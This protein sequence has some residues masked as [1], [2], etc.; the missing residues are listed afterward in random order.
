MPKKLTKNE[1][2]LRAITLH[3]DKYDYSKVD[4]VNLK[5]EVVITCNL[6]GDFTQIAKCHL[7]GSK[8]PKC[9]S[10]KDKSPQDWF[11]TEAKKVHGDRYD[12]STVSVKDKTTPIEIKC[13]VH[14]SFYQ[15]PVNH[16]A[17]NN[18]ME[19][20]REESRLT[21][22]QFISKSKE[23]HGN[24]Y[25][26]DNTSYTLAD[27]KVIITCPVHGDFL[28][29]PY[30]HMDGQGCNKCKVDSTRLTTE[31]FI[32]KAIN[33]HKNKYSY[34]KVEYKSNKEPVTIYCPVHGY[35]NQIADYHMQ[36]RGCPECGLTSYISK[37]EN[38]IVSHIKSLGLEV[39]QS[40][41]SLI[42]PY[43]LDIII[44]EKKIAIEYNGIRWHSEKFGKDKYYHKNKTNL[45][46]DKGYRL[47]HIW[48]DDFINDAK[49]EL[50]FIS[51]CLGTSSQKKVYARQ[52]TIKTI[53]NKEGRTF[54]DKHHIQ[55]SGTGTF[56]Y[57][58]FL[59]DE[60]IAVTSFL[61]KK[62]HAELTRHTSDRQIVGGL[63]K[64]TKLVS[65]ELKQDIL[66]FCDL[67]RFDGKSYLTCGYE[68]DKELLPDYKY[69]VGNERQHKFVWRKKNIEKKLPDIYNPD[70]T[71][72]EMMELADIPRIWDCGKL[73]LIYKF[74]QV[75][76]QE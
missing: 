67:S 3:G 44:P 47:I 33:I 51:Y 53:S 61:V 57:G 46:K 1:F 34:D 19:C 2:I 12:Y 31:T 66:S 32:I 56:Y 68:I 23:K 11:I 24:Y 58:M 69:V 55:G 42:S 54:L 65:K 30:A 71:E 10:Y 39:Q 52:T 21:T 63:G 29:K 7:K 37:A 38:T 43:E 14:G 48:E 60:L 18:C 76:V 16:L 26:Y 50:D 74:K 72:K 49:K 6:H 15:Q 25:S 62:D 70:L 59:E 28:Q 8:C 27:E 4:F 9:Y 20:S 22:E 13:K 73:R 75:G 17:G 41:R 35:Y 40:N 64:V 36:G 45:C 5:S